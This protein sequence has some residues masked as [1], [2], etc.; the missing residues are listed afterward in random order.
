[1]GLSVDRPDPFDPADRS[2]HVA[3]VK[4]MKVHRQRLMSCC[5]IFYQ[6]LTPILRKMKLQKSSAHCGFAPE[7]GFMK[8]VFLFHNIQLIIAETPVS[9]RPYSVLSLRVN[10]PD[11]A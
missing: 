4:I 6:K 9:F 8:I 5:K 10:H 7:T 1:V 3:K 2:C 11:I